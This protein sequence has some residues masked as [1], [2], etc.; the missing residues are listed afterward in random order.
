[1]QKTQGILATCI[2]ILMGLILYSYWSG[3]ELG[4]WLK[5]WIIVCI[6]AYLGR[7]Y[8]KYRRNREE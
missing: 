6:A 8:E 7:I 2:L 3:V 4:W 1:M 5:G